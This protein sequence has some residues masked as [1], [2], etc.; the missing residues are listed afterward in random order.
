MPGPKTSNFSSRV[1]RDGSASGPACSIDICKNNWG[2]ERP[3]ARLLRE[4][5]SDG[6]RRTCPDP[7][8][9]SSSLVWLPAVA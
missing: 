4:A 5:R 7:Q 9:L 2:A 1:P 3:A 6:L 8:R